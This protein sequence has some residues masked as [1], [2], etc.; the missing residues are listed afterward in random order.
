MAASFPQ[1]LPTSG[2]EPASSVPPQQ[3]C[4]LALDVDLLAP[5]ALR[6]VEAVG[7]VEADH[8]SFAAEGLERRFLIVDQSHH[9][10]AV[11]GDVGLADERII[12]VE[13]ADLDHRI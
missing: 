10:L 9:D 3:P 1:I 5:V 6:V 8:L 11:A 2:K 7:G 13:N 12:A 4:P